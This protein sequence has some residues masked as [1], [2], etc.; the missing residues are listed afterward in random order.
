M[1]RIDSA[2]TTHTSIVLSFIEKSPGH[3]TQIISIVEK[4]AAKTKKSAKN[5]QVKKLEKNEGF[6]L[7]RRRSAT[8]GPSHLASWICCCCRTTQVRGELHNHCCVVGFHSGH[9]LFTFFIAAQQSG[10]PQIP[11][12]MGPQQHIA[13][14]VLAENGKIKIM[15]GWSLFDQIIVIIFDSLFPITIWCDH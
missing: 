4:T 8:D 3:Y 10:E 2:H 14:H 7:C 5:M 1:W 11:G 15:I 12:T 6:L 9:W 13:I